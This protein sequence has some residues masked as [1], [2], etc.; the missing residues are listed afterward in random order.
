MID[1]IKRTIDESIDVKKKV[2]ETLPGRI[3]DAANLIADSLKSNKK[4]LV[5]GNGGSAADAQHLAGELVG[6]FKLERKAL[7]CIALTTD[8]SI[9]TAWSNDYS[10]ETIFERQVEALGQK[11]DVLIGIST[12]GNSANVIKALEKAKGLGIKTV[13]LLGKDGGK[14]KGMADVELVVPCNNTPRVQESHIMIL[15]IICEL[16]ERELK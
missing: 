12:S 7:P 1:D 6:R 16:I 3:Q 8:T 15:H 14:L 4:V 10:F 9:L 11:G 13:T 5:C 2:S